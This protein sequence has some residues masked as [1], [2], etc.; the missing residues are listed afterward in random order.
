MRRTH[1]AG[2]RMVATFD[3]LDINQDNITIDN[4]LIDFGINDF[5]ILQTNFADKQKVI[6]DN[7]RFIKFNINTSVIADYET[8]DYNDTDYLTVNTP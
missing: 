5:G 2:N 8:G 7:T 1:T 6:E 3:E 4:P